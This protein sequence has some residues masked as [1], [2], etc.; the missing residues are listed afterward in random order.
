MSVLK[1]L[2]QQAIQEDLD[3]SGS[4][5]EDVDKPKVKNLDEFEPEES[6]FKDQTNKQWKN[7]SR[8]LIV[9]ARGSAPGFR[10]LVSDLVDL[11]P[12]SKKEAKVSKKTAIEDAL[13]LAESLSC[14]HIMYFEPRKSTDLY[15]WM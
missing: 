11:L 14:N 7:R 12:H 6:A 2:K 10:H 5:F 3:S 13:D 1:M 8:V 4:D 9:T 15:V